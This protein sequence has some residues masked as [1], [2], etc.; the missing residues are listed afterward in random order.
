MANLSHAFGED[1][2]VLLFLRLGNGPLDVE[3]PNAQE[4][5]SATTIEGKHIRLLKV[6]DSIVKE[7]SED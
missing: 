7:S 2:G 1:S 3:S 5:K 4:A 6:C